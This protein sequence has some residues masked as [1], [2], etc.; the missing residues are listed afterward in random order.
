MNDF[1]FEVRV[2]H[3][4]FL[5]GWIQDAYNEEQERFARQKVELHEASTVQYSAKIDLMDAKAKK[6]A[7]VQAQRAETKRRAEAVVA[8]AKSVNVMTRRIKGKFVD[9]EA[10]VGKED[11]DDE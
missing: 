1:F 4:F 11:E 3:Y 10:G 5:H 8:Q 9:D 6:V 7:V 2:D